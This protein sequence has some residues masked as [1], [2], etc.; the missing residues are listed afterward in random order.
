[1]S[2]VCCGE[3]VSS[4]L[5]NDLMCWLIRLQKAVHSRLFEACADPE[6]G[7]GARGR[8]PN[9]HLFQTSHFLNML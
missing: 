5:V 6:G 8:L 3:T 2:S 4:V 7:A 1:M 9:L